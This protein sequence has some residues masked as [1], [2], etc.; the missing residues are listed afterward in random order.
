M[1]ELQTISWILLATAIASQSEPTDTSGISAIADGIN[2]AV[3]T[4]SEMQSAISWLDTKGLVTKNGKK[5]ELTPLGKKEYEKSSD[6]TN[7]LLK[8]WNNLEI[9]IKNYA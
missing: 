8:I 7:T 5:Y 3:P 9:R 2:H 1:T 4:H 6:T